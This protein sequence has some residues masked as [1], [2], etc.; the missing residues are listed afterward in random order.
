MVLLNS[1]GVGLSTISN[2]VYRLLVAILRS[3]RKCMGGILR[4]M[5]NL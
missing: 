2:S 1:L 3:N 5:M 4:L